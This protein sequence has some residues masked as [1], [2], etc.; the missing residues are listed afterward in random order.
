MSYEINYFGW[1]HTD[2]HDKVWGYVT[3]GDGVGAELYNFWGARGKKLSFKKY[4]SNYDSVIELKK[5]AQKKSDKGYR[6][7]SVM[8]IETVVDG[9]IETFEKQLTLAKLFGNFRGKKEEEEFS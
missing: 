8:K 1:N 9:F 7:I 4:P 2:G 6:E 5:L 3:I